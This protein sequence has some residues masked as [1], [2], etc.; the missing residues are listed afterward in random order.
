MF[1]SIFSNPNTSHLIEIF[2]WM[3]GAFLIG[4]FFGRFIKTK[5]KK[6]TIHTP[7]ENHEDLNI[8][9]DI[10][11][12]RAT[13]TFE[14]GGVELIRTVPIKNQNGLNFNRIGTA[15]FQNKDD[16]QQIKGIG[17]SIEEKLNTIGI[18]TFKQISNFNDKDITKITDLIKF[19][20]GRIERDDWVG[21]AF[22]LLNGKEK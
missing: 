9:D 14:R 6:S 15:T 3:L 4:I 13:Q 10:S 18:F 7:L 16:L 17:T 11:K 20:P 1:L 5:E 8:V 19:F 21:Q 12:I 22:N 2:C